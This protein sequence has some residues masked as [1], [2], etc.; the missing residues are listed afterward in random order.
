MLSGKFNFGM[1]FSA[2]TTASSETQI[3][4]CEISQNMLIVDY[5]KN[6]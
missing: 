1:Y 6:R 2:V 3:I 4:L 5:I